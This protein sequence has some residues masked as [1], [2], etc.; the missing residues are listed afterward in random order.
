MLNII[1]LIIGIEYIKADAMG[2]Q[3]PNGLLQV[4]LGSNENSNAKVMNALTNVATE[5][6]EAAKYASE[7]QS[8]VC[9]PTHEGLVVFNP[10]GRCDGNNV[11]KNEE[12]SK[13]VRSK[14]EL[15][16]KA[17]KAAAEQFKNYV[18]KG[19]TN[20]SPQQCV[21]KLDKKQAACFRDSVFSDIVKKVA[22]ELTTHSN[23]AQIWYKSRLMFTYI[24]S[25]YHY[26]MTKAPAKC[27]T[28]FRTA[29]MST[30]ANEF[31]IVLSNTG[32]PA[33]RKVPDPCSPCKEGTNTL[34]GSAAKCSN[35]CDPLTEF[36]L[37]GTNITVIDDTPSKKQTKKSKQ[38]S[39]NEKEN[40]D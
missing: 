7:C 4:P 31:G 13:C 34:E 40:D 33:Q 26:V 20:T 16:A 19:T 29:N 27:T 38:A 35:L 12:I 39:D 15:Y 21:H 11:S 8:S 25:P 9:K 17:A 22:W 23:V 36:L 5:R 6:A 18:A 28:S 37:P 14:M 1:S 10:N 32:L 3:G 24:M 2:M 30:K